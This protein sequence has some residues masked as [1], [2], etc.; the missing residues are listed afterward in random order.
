MIVECGEFVVMELAF[1]VCGIVEGEEGVLFQHGGD[2]DRS[3]EVEG[4]EHRLKQH[5][6]GGD[7]LEGISE[8]IK[9]IKK[10]RK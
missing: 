5:G 10:I 8:I 9:N 2:G 6:L 4:V 1:N 3:E 7:N